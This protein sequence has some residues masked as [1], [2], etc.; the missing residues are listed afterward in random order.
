MSKVGIHLGCYPARTDWLQLA[1][2]P[3]VNAYVV[4]DGFDL[5]TVPLPG[6][7]VAY[8]PLSDQKEVVRKYAPARYAQM[9]R[10]EWYVKGSRFFNDL[11]WLNEPNLPEESGYTDPLAAIANTVIWGQ[12]VVAELRRLFPGKRLHS[13]PLSPH[14]A[15]GDWRVLYAQMQPLI[16][17]CD[18]LGVHSYFD[19]PVSLTYLHAQYPAQVIAI[20]ECG[21]PARGSAAYGRRLRAYWAGLPSYVEWAAA[22]IWTAP[23]GQ[24]DDWCLQG[25]PAAQ[26]L[27]GG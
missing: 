5:P 17:A 8:R 9:I 12:E 13:P 23:A 3:N 24:F 14:P 10:D 21:S 20:S 26:V 16:A 25:T 11:L 19:L 27:M 7:I 1:A 18:L 15:H 6:H 4:L 22:F 2:L